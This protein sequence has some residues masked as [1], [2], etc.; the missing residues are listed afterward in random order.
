VKPI[1]NSPGACDNGS[2]AA[3][4]LSL[5]VFFKKNSL[6]NT[7]LKFIWCAAEEWGIYGSK[8]YVKAHKE[9]IVAKKDTSYVINIDM[10]GSELAYL[11]KTGLIRKKDLNKKLN[12]L[13]EETAKENEI[14][15]RR[16][17]SWLASN[18]D[19]APFKKEKLEACSFTAMKDFKIVHSPE[20]TIDK[21]KP[22]KL[23]DAVQLLSKVIEKLDKTDGN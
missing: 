3:I 18:T 4:L 1:N 14:E 5:A 13:I 9:E 11:V 16:F 22:E 2:G 6:N 7:Q 8:G 12:D 21:V 10:V 19:M 20:D 17:N 23:D 15:A